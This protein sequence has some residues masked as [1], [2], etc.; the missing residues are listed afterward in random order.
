MLGTAMFRSIR[1]TLQL[2]HAGI[3][4]LA[5]LSFAS[6]LYIAV[7]RTEFNRIDAELQGAA[8]VLA[9]GPS[10]PPPSWFNSFRGQ[11]NRGG[12]G[13][14]GGPNGPN[15]WSGPGGPGGPNGGGG[16]NGFNGPIGPPG[17]GGSQGQ[18]GPGPDEM[19]SLPATRPSYPDRQGGPGRQPPDRRPQDRPPRGQDW[20]ANVPADVLHR[21][22]QDQ[23]D[24]PY[25]VVW[26]GSGTVIRS[27]SPSLE[28]PPPGAV[29]TPTPVPATYKDPPQFRQRG[30]LREVIVAGTRGGIK[31]LVGRSVQAEQSRMARFRWTLFGAGAAVLLVGLCG[32]WMLSERA[33]RPIRIIT[34][35][36]QSISGSDLSRRIKVEDT[37][38]ELGSLARTLNETFDRLETAFQRQVRFTADASHELRTPLSVIHSHAELALTRDRSARE[39]RQTIET[40]L[41]AAKRMKNLVETLLVLARADAGGLELRYERFDLCEVAEECVA[42]LTPQAHE[43]GI[44][45][46]T[47]FAKVELDADRTRMAQLLTNLLSNAIRYNRD[48]GSV[49]LKITS[50]GA[51]GILTVADTGVGIAEADQPRVFERFF[52]ADKARSREAGGSGLGLAICQSIVAAHHG[53]ISF[54]SEYGVG[55]TFTVKLPLRKGQVNAA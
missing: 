39:Y 10:G 41:R 13:G 32:G 35:T 37:H 43:R 28:I 12:P 45:V 36:A 47:E 34:D 19:G 23:S 1:W 2:W 53:S 26:D 22:G 17:P 9:V 46:T 52:R 51:Q 48:S 24:Q 25:W 6:A 42:M 49:N 18:F 21:I 31:I 30:S 3:L 50:D 8:E 55:T 4:A 29:S 20:W 40:S 27:S 15:G 33:T 5:L 14:Q 16:N 44:K 54:K 7:S 11:G 38:S